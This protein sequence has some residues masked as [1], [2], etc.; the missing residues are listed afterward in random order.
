MKLAIIVIGCAILLACALLVLRLNRSNIGIL[1]TQQNSYLIFYGLAVDE[2]G[3][4]LV[5]AVFEIEIEAIP[6]GW[7]YETRGK[8]HERS[9]ITAISGP[10]GRFQFDIVGHIIRVTRAEREGYRHFY[11]MDT[12]FSRTQG[13]DNTSIRLDAW[14]DPWYRSD[15][16]YP[17]VY[18]FVKEGVNQISVLPTRGGSD[19]G[20]SQHWIRNEPV[21]PAKPSLK[22]VVY[23]GPATRKAE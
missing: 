10:D 15:P 6:A 18:V 7:T 4:S 17:A 2:N 3:K 23:V 5:G 8:P 11:E 19:S 16:Q 14:G 21:W 12:G 22:D 20:G 9:K 13:A 1:K